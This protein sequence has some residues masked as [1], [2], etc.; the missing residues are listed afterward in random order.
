LQD[1]SARRDWDD[2]GI[3]LLCSSAPAKFNNLCYQHYLPPQL[4]VIWCSK[5]EYRLS[6]WS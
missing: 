2:D 5:L 6:S 4:E 3:M 1:F